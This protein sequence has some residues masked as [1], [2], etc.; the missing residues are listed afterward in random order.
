MT[1]ATKTDKQRRMDEIRKHAQELAPS[2]CSSRRN[3][4]WG[5]GPL[6]VLAA[7]VGEAPGNTE[8]RA[9]RPFVGSSGILLTQE[10]ARV[11]L[12]R[13]DF[14]ITNVV[15]CR[16]TKQV[17]SRITNRAPTAKEAHAWSGILMDELKVVEPKI[18]LCAGVLAARMLLDKNFIMSQ[19]RGKWFDG[20]FGTRV[21]ATYHPAYVQR[22][23][24]LSNDQV[25]AEF[26]SD[27]QKMKDAIGKL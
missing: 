3:I 21:I 15:K 24:G 17:E 27:L 9:G 14:W 25:I 12:I 23:I 5:E 13:S 26:R 20:P 4:V 11:D 6:T 18:I 8:D 16:P 7:I 19:D 2:A 1:S 22:Q 10:L